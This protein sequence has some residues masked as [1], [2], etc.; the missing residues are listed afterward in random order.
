[1]RGLGRTWFA[2]DRLVGRLAESYS[3]LAKRDGWLGQLRDQMP[4]NDPVASTDPN[5]K[6]LQQRLERLKRLQKNAQAVENLRQVEQ[7]GKRIAEVQSKLEK[8]D[9]ARSEGPAG[10][11]GDSLII[12]Q[13]VVEAYLRTVGRFPT[14]VEISRCQAH[15]ADDTD[16]ISGLT[17]VVWALM[18][19]K[20][21]I[22]NH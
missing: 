17:G 6:E 12:E 3:L 5:P 16:A 21:F 10:S 2:P 8:L 15:V 19:T 4:G 14:K 20:E 18:N 22:V 1:M 7:L 9:Q 13:L 11:K